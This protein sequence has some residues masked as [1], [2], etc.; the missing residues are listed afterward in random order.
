M[1]AGRG[2]VLASPVGRSKETH[3]AKAPKKSKKGNKKNSKVNVKDLDTK[4]DPKGGLL[5]AV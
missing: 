2:A 4:K 5:P 1:I 3:M